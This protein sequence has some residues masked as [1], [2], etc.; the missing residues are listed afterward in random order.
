[1]AGSLEFRMAH[2]TVSRMHTGDVVAIIPA[3]CREYASMPVICSTHSISAGAERVASS[4]NP[5]AHVGNFP[6][7]RFSNL[8]LP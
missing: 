7:L 6:A 8:T 1:M 3:S 2:Y 5:L 4:G